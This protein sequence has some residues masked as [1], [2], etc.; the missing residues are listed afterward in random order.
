VCTKETEGETFHIINPVQLEWKQFI[1][2]VIQMGHP[3]N[4]VNTEQFMSLF[5]DN[6]LSDIQKYAL[7]LMVPLL[8]EEAKNSSSIPTCQD[9]QRYLQGVGVGCELPNEKLV[10]NLIDYGSSLGFFPPQRT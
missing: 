6:T 10:S 8:E 4:N 5:E 9:T 2:Y 7:E 3:I 1:E